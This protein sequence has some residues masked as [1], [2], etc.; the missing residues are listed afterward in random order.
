MNGAGR[1]LNQFNT[2]SGSVVRRNGKAK[3]KMKA[4]GWVVFGC[5]GLI[6]ITKQSYSR[7]KLLISIISMGIIFAEF[8]Q[9]IVFPLSYYHV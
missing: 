5:A 7:F 1:P 6:T 2:L 3:G 8:K 9:F 4:Q